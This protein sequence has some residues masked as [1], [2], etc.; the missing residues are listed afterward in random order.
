MRVCVCVHARVCVCACA[1]A[2]ARVC[3][4]TFLYDADNGAL[5]ITFTE[6]KYKIVAAMIMF[7]MHK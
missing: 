3:M 5:F 7:S 4:C 6:R 1:R 2:R